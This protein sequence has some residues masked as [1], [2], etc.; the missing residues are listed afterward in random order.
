MREKAIWLYTLI[1]CLMYC[2]VYD[3]Y[4]EKGKEDYLWLSTP[5]KMLFYLLVLYN[6]LSI[7]SVNAFINILWW[8]PFNFTFLQLYLTSA[9]CYSPSQRLRMTSFTIERGSH[10]LTPLGP[11]PWLVCGTVTTLDWFIL[12]GN[13]IA[14]HE[15][16]DK[17]R[18]EWNL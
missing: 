8:I 15:S 17:A 11:F 13:S 4:T 18:S 12:L 9:C 7:I 1:L 2:Y 3:N 6:P 14:V 5:V 16:R 10:N